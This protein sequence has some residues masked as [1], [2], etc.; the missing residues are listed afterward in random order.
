MDCVNIFWLLLFHGYEMGIT[1]IYSIK[2][3]LPNHTLKEFYKSQK[4]YNPPLNAAC[5]LKF[6]MLSNNKCSFHYFSCCLYASKP[7]IMP[8]KNRTQ[9]LGK[10]V[11]SD[12]K[13]F[14][15]K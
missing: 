13:G 6:T 8:A 3:S 4:F 10:I 11:H 9:L 2:S 12:K 1:S 15:C 7:T 5:I 14:K